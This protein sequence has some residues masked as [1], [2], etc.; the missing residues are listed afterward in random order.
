MSKKATWAWALWD[1]AEQP[2]PTIFQTFIFATY[3]TSSYF[4]D[5]DANAQALS[6]AGL[7]AGLLVAVISPVFG[8]RSDEAGHRK[9][10]LLINSAILIAIMAASYFVWFSMHSAQWCRNLHSS[11]TTQC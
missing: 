6:L 10:W 9:L 4:G 5:P 7:I 1:W 8:R 2:Y 3:L 11:I